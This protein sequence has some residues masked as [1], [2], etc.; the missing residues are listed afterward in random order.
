MVGW[1][2]VLT[3]MTVNPSQADLPAE[4]KRGDAATVAYV[5]GDSIQRNY[6]FIEAREQSMF[7]AVQ[8]SQLAVERMARPLQ[9]EAQELID[10]ASGPGVSGDEVQMA[11]NRLYEIEAQLAQIQ[12]E[13]QS[14]L[15]QLENA[16]QVEVSEKLNQEVGFFAKENGI[17]VVLN[18]G[19]SGEGVLYGAPGFDVTEA[20][21][22]FMNE[23]YE[24]ETVQD[25]SAE[26]TE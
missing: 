4:L 26:A 24:E 1:L 23:R 10:Y 21:L 22:E 6:R 19:L 14:R 7:T 12:N 9:E 25:A 5:H 11:Q 3:Y 16:L 8:Q 17:E 18:W 20:L 2:A 13:A 15:V